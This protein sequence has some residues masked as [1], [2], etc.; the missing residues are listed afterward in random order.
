MVC[1]ITF[2]AAVADSDNISAVVL[3]RAIDVKLGAARLVRESGGAPPPDV[4]RIPPTP[5]KSP[6]PAIV[7]PLVMPKAL[8]EPSARSPLTLLSVTAAPP[9]GPISF[10]R[11]P[12]RAGATLINTGIG[13]HEARV[14]TI[15][16]SVPRAAFAFASAK[17]KE[18]VTI[19]VCA[20]NRINTPQLAEEI[21]AG[22]QADMVSMAR[23]LLADPD[24]ST[25]QLRIWDVV[26]QP[27]I[28]HQ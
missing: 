12:L 25:S 16:T 20:S 3:A 23:P 14:P 1:A 26:A 18:S 27:G 4:T 24:P 5:V 28:D 21:I 9:T 6:E 11:V 8:S 13:W 17:L 19:P 10:G 7:T 15:V 22:G 2:C